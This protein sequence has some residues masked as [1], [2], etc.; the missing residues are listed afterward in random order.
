MPSGLRGS[1]NGLANGIGCSHA[2]LALDRYLAVIEAGGENKH[3]K[4][5]FKN[6][7]SIT[8]SDGYRLALTRWQKLLFDQTVHSKE[9]KVQDRLIVGLGSKSVT[10]TSITL[11]HTYGVPVIPGS[12]LKGLARHYLHHNFAGNEEAKKYLTNILFGDTDSAGYITFFDAWYIPVDNQLPLHKDVMTPHHM[13]Y[14]AE[15]G[16]S[17][18]TDFDDPNPVGFISAIGKY[19]VALK[20]PNDEWTELTF[21]LL[22]DALKYA[23]VGGKTSSGYGR[24]VGTTV[25]GVPPVAQP[26]QNLTEGMIEA[27]NGCGDYVVNG[28][29]LR[30]RWVAMK[31]G[32]A[33][34]TVAEAHVNKAKSV[35][36]KRLDS[37]LWYQV[38]LSYIDAHKPS[39]DVNG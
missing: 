4:D 28:G 24:L 37:K 19:L 14:N 5:L 6:A 12:A 26:V 36:I 32:P 16:K 18:P 39:E 13:E 3:K 23:G 22:E 38:L 11:H 15:K 30:D 20:G 7:A 31:E 35:K 21:R 8:V 29:G 25:P 2:G 1:L 10:E 34:L 27:I 17:T 9:M 33:K